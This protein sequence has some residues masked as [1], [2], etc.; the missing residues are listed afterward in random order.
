MGSATVH[1]RALALLGRH[2]EL[3]RYV[4]V[5]IAVTVVAGLVLYGVLL[6]VGLPAIERAVP[7]TG[8]LAALLQ[9]ALVAAALVAVAFV[10]VRFGVVLGSPWYGRLSERLEELVTGEA[11]PAQPLTV[12]GIARD[13]GRSVRYEAAKLLVVLPLAGLLLAANLVPVLGQG[14]A[15]GGGVLLG[16]FVACLDFLDPP[17]ERRRLS[18]RQKLRYVRGHLPRSGVFGLLCVPLLAV[19]V[20]NLLAIPLCVAA[21]TLFFCEDGGRGPGAD[22]R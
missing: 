11:P 17:L 7:G 6:A 3:W 9:L 19:P 8:L 18:F 2:R 16:A 15:A 10:V 20:V 5:P 13:L 12:R 4:L 22:R 14:V 21:G 1:L